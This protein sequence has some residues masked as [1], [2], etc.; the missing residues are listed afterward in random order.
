MKISKT[1]NWLSKALFNAD[2]LGNPILLTIAD[3]ES[4]ETPK[5]TTHRLVVTHES[6]KIFAFDVFGDALNSLIDQLGD[7]TDTWKSRKIKVML[8]K[9]TDGKDK[10][11]I[12]VLP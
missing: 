1:R 2:S 3:F 4:E 6:G 7:E 11:T 8:L 9:G 12:Q 5:G 10:K